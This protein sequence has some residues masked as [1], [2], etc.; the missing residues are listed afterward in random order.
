M[1]LYRC[2][3]CGDESEHD[4]RHYGCPKVGYEEDDGLGRTVRAPAPIRYP[5]EVE[6]P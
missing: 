1:T 4:G 5:V 2:P 6:K 3:E